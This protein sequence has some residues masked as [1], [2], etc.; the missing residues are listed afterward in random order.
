M[1]VRGPEDEE[2]PLLANTNSAY[3]YQ[4]D[5]ACG[6][7]SGR[8]GIHWHLSQCKLA[9][10]SR[11]VDDAINGAEVSQLEPPFVI[12]LKLWRVDTGED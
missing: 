1:I 12:L 10:G 6:R 4:K 8:D 7:E 11:P 3:L 2:A 9:S 5:R